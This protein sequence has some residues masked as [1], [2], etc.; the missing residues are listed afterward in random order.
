MSTYR[1]RSNARER[2]LRYVRRHAWQFHGAAVRD[3]MEQLTGEGFTGQVVGPFTVREVRAA[4]VR[5]GLRPS[6]AAELPRATG[7]PKWDRTVQVP[8]CVCTHRMD[9]HNING[10]CIA[11]PGVLGCGCLGFLAQGTDV[12]SASVTCTNCGAS[13]MSGW[14]TCIGCGASL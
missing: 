9:Q 11:L 6:L 4:R 7:T 3:A 14:A 12:L 5:L 2:A 10:L 1:L 13:N 8:T